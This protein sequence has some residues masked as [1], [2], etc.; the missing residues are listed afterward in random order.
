MCIRDRVSTQSTGQATGSTEGGGRAAGGM[1]VVLTTIAMGRRVLVEHFDGTFANCAPG[2]LDAVGKKV[3]AQLQDTTP[4]VSFNVDSHSVHTLSA[5]G[6]VYLTVASQDMSRAVAFAFLEKLQRRFESMFAVGE[7]MPEQWKVAMEAKPVLEAL[8]AGLNAVDKPKDAKTERVKAGLSGVKDDLIVNIEKV[9]DRGEK[10][11][12]L[13][14][15][16]EDLASSSSSF[17]SS[18]RAAARLMWWESVKQ[19]LYLAGFGL[20]GLV[21][22]LLLLCGPTLASCRSK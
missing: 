13:L 16:S 15:K 4:R 17:K 21:V 20:L 22:L 7:Q 18:A 2:H 1:P 6:V 12:S 11:D 10:M 14:D 9:I 8:M 19:K 3:L 5:H